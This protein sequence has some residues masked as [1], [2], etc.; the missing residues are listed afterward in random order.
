[1]SFLRAG[2]YKIKQGGRGRRPIWLAAPI[3]VECP[4]DDDGRLAD[5]PRLVLWIGA[6]RHER[7]TWEDWGHRL[8]PCSPAEHRRLRHAHTAETAT[9]GYSLREAPPI[10]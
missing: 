9:P 8:W 7:P 2:L 5:R 6:E 4:T 1:M 10:F 3:R